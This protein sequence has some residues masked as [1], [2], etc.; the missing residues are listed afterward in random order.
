MTKSEIKN[1]NRILEHIDKIHDYT[2]NLT[3]IDDFNQSSML[4]EAVVFNLA[5]IGEISKYGIS[6]STKLAY[7]AVPWREMNGF[8]NKMIH[9]YDQVDMTIVYETIKNDLKPLKDILIEMLIEMK[10]TP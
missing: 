6:D 3:N 2:K 4:V 1:I 9:D 5:Q 8:R 7:Q 10:E